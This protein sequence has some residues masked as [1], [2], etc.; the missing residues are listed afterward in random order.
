MDKKIEE[1]LQNAEDSYQKALQLEKKGRGD[2]VDEMGHRSP[3]YPY[4]RGVNLQGIL[5]VS[6]ALYQ[7]NK[8]I[9]ELLKNYQK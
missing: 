1:I 7:Q 2:G 6:L 3:S 4:E 9:I 5:H 8:V